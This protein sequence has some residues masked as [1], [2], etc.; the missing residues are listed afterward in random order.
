MSLAI[1]AMEAEIETL[2]GSQLETLQEQREVLIKVRSS[3]PSLL[4][5]QVLEGLE[6]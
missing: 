3:S 5:L 2:H 6:P 4:S 1:E